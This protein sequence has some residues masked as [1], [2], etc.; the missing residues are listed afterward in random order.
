LKTKERMKY[1]K[2]SDSCIKFFGKSWCN[3]SFNE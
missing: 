3:E 1:K 2:D